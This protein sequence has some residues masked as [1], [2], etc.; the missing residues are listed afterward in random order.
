M[1]ASKRI[2][3]AIWG[4]LGDFHPYLAIARELQARGH[5]CV[6]ATNNF[7]RD[8]IQSAGFEFAPMGPH[9]TPGDDVTRKIMHLSRGPIILL[10]ELILP[11]TRQAFVETVTAIKG[12]DLVVTH[13]IT[14]GAHVAAE[15]EEIAWA[16]TVLAPMGL[17]SL[18]EPTLSGHLALLSKLG[19]IGPI[20]DRLALDLGRSFTRRWTEPVR[21]LRV[22][23]GMPAGAHPYL[24]RTIFAATQSC[25]VL[26]ALRTASAR[27]AAAHRGYGLSLLR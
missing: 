1:P 13:P 15:K 27:L 22:E 26:A 16:S 14:Y 19:P 6:L 24:R 17:F 5:R 2:V 12:A 10:R 20:L 9:I 21:R 23:L 7:Y 8:R 25:P 3:F 11:Y 4:S 18:R